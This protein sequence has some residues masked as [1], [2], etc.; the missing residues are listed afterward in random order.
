VERRAGGQTAIIPLQETINNLMKL[1]ITT[2]LR[3][4]DR[5]VRELEMFEQKQLVD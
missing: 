3:E 5:V 2:M 4:F 1:E